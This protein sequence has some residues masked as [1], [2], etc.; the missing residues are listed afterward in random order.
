MFFV[1]WWSCC[2][3]LVQLRCRRLYLLNPAERPV[4][5]TTDNSSW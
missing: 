5:W 3:Q 2:Y 1:V 4:H